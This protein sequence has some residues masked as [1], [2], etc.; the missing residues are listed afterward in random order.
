[1]SHTCNAPF[2]HTNLSD[3][4]VSLGIGTGHVPKNE[5]QLISFGIDP[6]CCDIVLPYGRPKQ[7]H[8]SI[9]PRT[10][11]LLLH[12]DSDNS[13][14]ALLSSPKSGES[15]LSLPR[16]QHRQRV[17]LAS[18]N[19]ARIC[20]SNSVFRLAWSRNRGKALEDAQRMRKFSPDHA[21]I[22]TPLDLLENGRI[23]HKRIKILGEGASAKVYLTRNLKTGDHL[24]VKVYK[25]EDRVEEMGKDAVRKEVNLI[26]S[27]HHVSYQPSRHHDHG[28]LQRPLLTCPWAVSHT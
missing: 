10:C 13:S 14:T 16:A 21:Y 20:I 17:V 2:K 19:N 12:D 1:V 6:V 26:E 11:E 9:H 18:I 25:F 28:I 24:A 15:T 27:L 7:C 22:S 3:G 8:F 4:T 5:G 23:T